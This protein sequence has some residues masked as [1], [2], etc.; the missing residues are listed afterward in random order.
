MFYKM[1]FI[2]L[3]PFSIEVFWY[4]MFKVT[5]T[6]FQNSANIFSLGDANLKP[7]KNAYDSNS[8]QVRQFFYFSKFITFISSNTFTSSSQYK[9]VLIEHSIRQRSSYEKKIVYAL[10]L[11]KK[12]TLCSI[13]MKHVFNTKFT[14]RGILQKMKICIALEKMYR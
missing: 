11:Q 7:I 4:Q 6:E 5:V 3:F 14:S 9:N 8:I 12:S 2:F 13:V 1:N 10:Q